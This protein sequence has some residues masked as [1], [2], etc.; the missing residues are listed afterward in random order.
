M[1][2]ISETLKEFTNKTQKLTAEIEELNTELDSVNNALDKA[3]KSITDTIRKMANLDYERCKQECLKMIEEGKPD[4]LTNDQ[5][6]TWIK[7]GQSL[8]GINPQP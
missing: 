3:E 2:I 7:T 8:F 1:N 5:W 4:H 6:E